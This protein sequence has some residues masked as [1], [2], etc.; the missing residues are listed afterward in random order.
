MSYP[1]ASKKHHQAHR[2][3][4]TEIQR[5]REN[6]AQ[7][8]V[9]AGAHVAEGLAVLGDAHRSQEPPLPLSYLA[10]ECCETV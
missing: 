10:L 8:D 1:A 2:N 3:H 6:R 9:L 5:V 7:Q 4:N